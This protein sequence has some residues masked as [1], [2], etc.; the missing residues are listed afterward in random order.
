MK[1]DMQAA[2]LRATS[3]KNWYARRKPHRPTQNESLCYECELHFTH[4]KQKLKCELRSYVLSTQDENR[5]T[6][7][8]T[9]APAQKKQRAEHK[10]RVTR[11]K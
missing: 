11:T 5:Y 9:H 8:E 2:K 10:S 3:A 6:N 7:C 4:T 1:T